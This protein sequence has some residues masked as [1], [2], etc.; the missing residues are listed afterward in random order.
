MYELEKVCY[1]LKLPRGNNFKE[2]FTLSKDSESNNN[3][4]YIF[5]GQYDFKGRVAAYIT[6]HIG[7]TGTQLQHYLGN[8]TGDKYLSIL[9]E[10][11]E[12][13]HFIPTQYRQ[14]TDNRHLYVQAFLGYICTHASQDDIA[15]IIKEYFIFPNDHLLPKT[16]IPR[17][18]W[19][20]LLFI[21]K[22]N[23]L[24]RPKINFVTNEDGTH[25]FTCTCNTLFE[26]SHNSVSYIYARKK[27]IRK[28]LKIIA[29][30]LEQQLAQQQ[31]HLQARAARQQIEAEKKEADRQQRLQEETSRLQKKQ[32]IKAE[33]DRIKAIKRTEQDAQR[34]KAKKDQKQKKTK[35]TAYREYSVEEIKAMSTNKRRR[36]EDLG[37]I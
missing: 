6:E 26:A 23:N 2:V 19:D 36:L 15:F 22:Q 5:A 4:R 35:N 7:G 30:T 13:S 34:R 3:S 17:N 11:W 31:Q 10:K 24:P 8:I 16:H 18:D 21:C 25:T 37:I 14:A 28:M 33:R 9:F 32:A 1:R 29:T 27:C 12:M 20:M